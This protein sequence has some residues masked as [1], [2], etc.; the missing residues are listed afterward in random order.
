LEGIWGA[1]AGIDL[2]GACAAGIVLAGAAAAGIVLVGACAAGIVLAGATGAAAAGIDLAGAAGACAAGIV[3][4][5]A[6]GA[7]AAGVDLVGACAAGI[8]LAGG[9]ASGIC[10]DW[11]CTSET[12]PTVRRE[13][14]TQPNILQPLIEVVSL[15]SR[16]PERL[17]R[18]DRVH[19]GR[20]RVDLLYGIIVCV[21]WEFCEFLSEYNDFLCA[22]EGFSGRFSKS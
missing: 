15:D 19:V 7:A 11:A 8:V 21:L 12:I 5:G 10:F 17:Y 13:A 18:D 14:A 6:A 2:A 20:D 4:A 22:R 9:T 16:C 3:L 1:A